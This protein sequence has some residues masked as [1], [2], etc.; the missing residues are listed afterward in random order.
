MFKRTEKLEAANPDFVA[1]SSDSDMVPLGCRE[2]RGS[3]AREE[4][5]RSLSPG[6]LLGSHP[7]LLVTSHKGLQDE[8]GLVLGRG[9]AQGCSWELGHFL[10][11]VG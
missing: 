4:G 2:R 8:P 7:G 1:A 6:E 10:P 5:S 11:W 3:G 9:A